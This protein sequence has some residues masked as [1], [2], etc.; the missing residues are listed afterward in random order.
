MT[1]GICF[2]EAAPSV[3]EADILSKKA[4]KELLS[5]FQDSEPWAFAQVAISKK[6]STG[7]NDI[8]GI[9]D[10]EQRRAYRMRLRDLDMTTKPNTVACLNRVQTKISVFASAEFGMDFKEFGGEEIVRYPEGGLF[11]PHIDT[12]KGNSQR[13]FTV[14]IYLNDDYKDGETS[15]PDLNYKCVPKAGRVV[16]FLSTEL[17]SGLPVIGGEKNIIVFWGFFPGSVDKD[18]ISSF[19]KKDELPNL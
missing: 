3:F 11:K 6:N 5:E 17:H 19:F 18:R 9:V 4:C 10:T 13:A 12:H 1:Q 2:K 16:L 15:F 14:I 8:I 7:V